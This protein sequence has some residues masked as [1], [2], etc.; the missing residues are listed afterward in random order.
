MTP[1]HIVATIDRMD[2]CENYCGKL[3]FKRVSLVPEAY[4]WFK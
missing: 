3:I 4:Y 1:I 2:K